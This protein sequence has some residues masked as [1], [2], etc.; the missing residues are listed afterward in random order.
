MA[1]SV[2]IGLYVVLGECSEE[3]GLREHGCSSADLRFIRYK[4]QFDRVALLDSRL[5]AL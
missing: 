2:Y 3:P 1:C 5:I 4:H